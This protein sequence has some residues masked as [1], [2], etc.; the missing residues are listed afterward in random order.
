MEPVTPPPENVSSVTSF[1][2]HRAG[3]FLRGDQ[4]VTGMAAW[5]RTVSVCLGERAVVS[6]QQ[7]SVQQV[8]V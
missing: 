4:R 3:P 5:R 7:V 6:E 2:E 1:P 8:C